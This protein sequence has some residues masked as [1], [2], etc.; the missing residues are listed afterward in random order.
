[1]N[2][3]ELQ[4]LIA[5]G[6][7]E[8]LELKAAVPPPEEIARHL[9][10][11]ANTKGGLLVFG[12]KE[13]AQFVG[14]NVHRAKVMVSA[15][16]RF[17]SPN[18]S[19]EVESLVINGHP[20]VFAHIKPSPELVSASGGYYRRVG[21]RI[22]PMKADEIRAHA[23]SEKNDDKALAELSAAVAAQ[24]QTIDQ[25]RSDFNKVN[26]M[27]R[28]IGIALLGAAAGALLKHAFDVFFP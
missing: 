1:M 27:P 23:A 13:P 11:F 15:A 4:R 18:V 3:Q 21:D 17:L 19:V 24:T 10:T 12:V 20:V 16:Q 6:E 5:K 26:S 8:Q 14:V 25:L 2:E 28:K 9:A 7:D 22:R